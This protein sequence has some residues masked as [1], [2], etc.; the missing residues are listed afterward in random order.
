MTSFITAVVYKF[1][2]LPDY[3]ALREPLK[4]CCLE[5][6]LK[7]TLHLASEGINGTL[8]GT[9]DGVH[10][11]LAFLRQNP[12]LAD[13][14]HREY[15]TSEIPFSRMK[16]K[17]KKEIVT[18]RVAEANP[19][20][21]VGTY[22]QPKNWNAII[23][24]PN[25]FVVDTRND[26]E[27]EIGTFEK[28]VDPNI[29]A[30]VDFPDFIEKNVDP[31]QHKKIAMFCTGGIRCEKASSYMLQE[32]FETVYHLEGGILNYLAEIPESESLWKGECFVFD[33][34]V[35]LQNELRPGSYTLDFKTG[36]PILISKH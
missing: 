3:E 22:I 35:A 31:K 9:V 14:K 34:R 28:A 33:E 27:V 10:A 36:E 16:V 12:P 4:A 25:V 32:G 24:D 26:Y 17:L 23:S 21:A 18:F 8:A 11:V 20:T 13:L 7:G 2:D 6:D 19:N 1:V 15:S 29:K 5:H 30:F